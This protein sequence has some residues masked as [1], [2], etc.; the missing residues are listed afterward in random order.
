MGDGRE[1]EVL[2][3]MVSCPCAA[4]PVSVKQ[5]TAHLCRLTAHVGQ[6]GQNS[7]SGWRGSRE[8]PG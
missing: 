8:V 5:E 3:A 7:S 2:A 6:T 1:G 4:V